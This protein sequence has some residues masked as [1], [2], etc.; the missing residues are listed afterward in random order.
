M[1]FRCHGCGRWLMFNDLDENG[2]CK[3][4]RPDP[5]R[6]PTACPHCDGGGEPLTEDGTCVECGWQWEPPAP[7]QP[8][9]GVG[10]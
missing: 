3:D 9:E 4:C 10:L 5:N 1:V 2:L 8:D 6:T 7:A